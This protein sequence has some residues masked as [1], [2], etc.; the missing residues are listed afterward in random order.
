MGPQSILEFS[1]LTTVS[2]AHDLQ[3]LLSIMAR[4]VDSLT[5]NTRGPSRADRD[6]ADLNA[7]IDSAFRLSRELL[8]AVGL[9]QTPES[10]VLDVSE[11][12][13]RC[14]GMIQRALG[15]RVHLVVNAAE[16]GLLVEAVPV[17]VEWILLNLVANARDAMPEGGVLHIQTDSVDRWIGPN[18][19]PTGTEQFVSI[20]VRDEGP[21]VPDHNQT[22]LFT[23]FFTTRPL[24][25]GL[26][27]TS[28]AV[29]VRALKGWLYVESAR[30]S[31]ASVHVLLPRWKSA[32]PAAP[33]TT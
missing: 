18:E 12:I 22:R 15:D 26:G 17:H 21:G 4:C 29:S 6:V 8:A 23:P 30:S 7:A 3:N 2:L 11:L 25:T 13:V 28:V 24:G 33:P 32:A 14:R 16:P 19:N 5:A 1:A 9:Q 20:T 27:L 10:I 31:G